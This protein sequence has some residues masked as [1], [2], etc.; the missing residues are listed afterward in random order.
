MNFFKKLFKTS[1]KTLSSEEETT[2][3]EPVVSSLDDLFVQNFINKG[4]KFLY[5]LNKQ[6]V[7][8]TLKQISLENNWPNFSCIQAPLKELCKH[9]ELEISTSTQEHPFLTSCEHLVADS[10]NIMLSS[11]QLTEMKLHVLSSHFIIVAKT[12]QIVKN[13][14]EGLTGIKANYKGKIPSNI[15]EIKSYSLEQSKEKNF[16]DYGFS[17]S[18]DLY[19]ILVEDL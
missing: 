15:C 8:S 18:K 12:S 14:G 9:A 10:G 11:N 3:K 4:G 17:N 1:D 5:C 6:E 7:V 2:N 13:M 19:L 16:M